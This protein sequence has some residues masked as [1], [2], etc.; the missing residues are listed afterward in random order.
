MTL[1]DTMKKPDLAQPPLESSPL[2]MVRRA[3]EPGAGGFPGLRIAALLRKAVQDRRDT[4]T[5]IEWYR[6][7]GSD[8]NGTGIVAT[9]QYIREMDATLRH[10]GGRFILALWPLLVPWDDGYPLREIHEHNAGFAQ[11]R[12]I[13]FVDLLPALM[14]RKAPELWVHPVD[15][16]PNEVAS[17]LAAQR[18]A[19][20]ILRT[21]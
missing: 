11:A 18:L 17:A 14:T 10:R 20:A 2:V 15:R 21:P 5:M 4:Q 6:R 9:R 3:D 8:E 19:A 1:N 13:E 16:H 12:S 7:L